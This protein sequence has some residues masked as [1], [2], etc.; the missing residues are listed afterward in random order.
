VGKKSVK[1][2]ILLCSSTA[3][4]QATIMPFWQNK[5]LAP[6]LR[7][8]RPFAEVGYTDA[9]ILLEIERT[10]VCDEFIPRLAGQAQK[11]SIRIIL[12]FFGE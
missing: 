6:Q 2:F 5:P 3:N 1:N 10:K 7:L 12:T 8:M 9:S 11:F 4:F